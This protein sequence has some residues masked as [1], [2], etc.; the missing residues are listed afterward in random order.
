MKEALGVV[1]I[2]HVILYGEDRTVRWQ[3][4]PADPTHPLTEEVVA[5]VIAADRKRR[6]LDPVRPD[7]VRPDQRPLPDDRPGDD[8]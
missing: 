4:F 7:P 2:P 1:G 6:G 8:R 3:G 5:A